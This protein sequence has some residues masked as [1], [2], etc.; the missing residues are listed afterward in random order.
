M[1]TFFA[2]A[3]AISLA[4]HFMDLLDYPENGGRK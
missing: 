1:T 4:S 3:S 2:I